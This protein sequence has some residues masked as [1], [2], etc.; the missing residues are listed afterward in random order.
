VHANLSFRDPLTG[1]A[2]SLPNEI[3]AAELAAP[4]PADPEALADVAAAL[5]TSRGV[6]IVGR[7]QVESTD[8]FL[9]ANELGWPIL[10]DHRSG[11]RIDSS[12]VIRHFDSLLRDDVFARDHRPDVV[13]RVGEI[14]S[15]K[16][17]SHWL[18]AS[19]LEGTRVISGSPYGRL[20]DPE[21]VASLHFDEAGGI[22][23]LV[24]M[25]APKPNDW[26][27]TSWTKADLSAEQA[28]ATTLA[29]AGTSE[30]AI[31]QAAFDAVPPAGALM[32]SSSMPVRDVEWYGPKRDDV[33][34]FANR[35]ANGIDGIVATAIGIA[36]A[37][38]PTV[39]LIGDVAFLH[40]SSSLIA[41]R[42]RPIDLTIVVVNN[43]GGGI[44][45]FL[46]QHQLLEPSAYEPLFGTPHGTDVA[47][48]VQ[49]HGI[50]VET[51]EGPI[52]APQGVRVVLATT[53][54]S[55][56]LAL[57]NELN[58][59]VAEALAHQREG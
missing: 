12:R 17:V 21:S 38:Q 22:E 36:L 9:L 19:A 20:I 5:G 31:A 53:E 54:R 4:L 15:S 28:I 58:T 46:P 34:V 43:D 56:N 42:N 23:Q 29:Q 32:V 1:T 40:D 41:L 44:F 52:A 47:G 27:L 39:C 33:D 59:A 35:G 11:C 45:S 3:A 8:L 48:L 26:W 30:V 24:H 14:V 18:L 6:I 55:S 57:H 37:D 16:A 50:A 51:W 25:V 7:T 13:L 49:A 10:A 2:G